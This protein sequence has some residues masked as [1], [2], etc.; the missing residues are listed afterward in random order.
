MKFSKVIHSLTILRLS[1][2]ERMSHILTL[3]SALEN[4]DI[5][6]F[7]YGAL[8]VENRVERNRL[9]LFDHHL[10]FGGLVVQ[11]THNYG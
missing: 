10:S 2:S 7:T 11:E 4:L 3:S 8:R 1:T 9:F 5:K 6:R